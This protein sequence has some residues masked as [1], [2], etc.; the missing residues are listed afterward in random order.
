ME[1]MPMVT[2]PMHSLKMEHSGLMLMVTV[3]ETIHRATTLMFGQ[4]TRLNV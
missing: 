2:I 1:T 3:V 4:M